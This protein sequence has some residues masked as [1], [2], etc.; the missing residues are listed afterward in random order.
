MPPFGACERPARQPR[1]VSWTYGTGQASMGPAPCTYRAALGKSAQSINVIMVPISQICRKTTLVVSGPCKTRHMFYN[2]KNT[3]AL[4]QSAPIP[5]YRY[6]FY[7]H[8]AFRAV[9]CD[10]SFFVENTPKKNM[11][12]SSYDVDLCSIILRTLL[13]SSDMHQCLITDISSIVP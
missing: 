10:P 8:S 3:S 5:H 6:K 1:V 12:T 2:T 7:P 11:L 4:L 9:P 13:H